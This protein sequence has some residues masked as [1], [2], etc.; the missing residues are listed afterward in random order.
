MKSGI[1]LI[2]K[3]AG[4]SSFEA[5]R[6]VKRAVKVR[7]AGHAGTLDPFATGL[8]LLCLGEATKL[9]PFLMPEPKTYRASVKLGEETDTQDPTGR[10]IARSEKLPEPQ[11]IYEAAARFLGEIEQIP[12]MY[13]ALH[14]QGERLYKKARRGETVAVKPRK[15]TIYEL[16]VQEL[17]LPLVTLEVTC[18]QG[19][20]IRTLAADLGRT[21]G[22][23]GHLAALRRL[24]VGPFRVEQA[25]TLEAMEEM[26]GE[27]LASRIIPLAECLPGFRALAV[28]PEDA[29][30]LRHGR[31]LPW[32]GNHLGQGE[33]VRVLAG[34]DLL[35]VAAVRAE[36][37]RLVLAPERVFGTVSSEQ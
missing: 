27:E 23:G 7:K 12:P 2:D 37:G 8:L 30:H 21:L 11:Q 16:T 36:T 35:A 33:R 26:A 17:A 1:L 9:V 25:L 14:H 19:T 22:C 20:Y 31:T 13:S 6:R 10:V 15:V 29:A 28:G 32:P 24:Q 5:V 4:P 34:G 3:P 18:S